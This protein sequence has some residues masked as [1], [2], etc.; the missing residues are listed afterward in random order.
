MLAVVLPRA[1]SE[2][3]A[4]AVTALH[5][6]HTRP[7]TAAAATEPGGQVAAGDGAVRKG[8]IKGG[9]QAVTLRG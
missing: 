9:E 8:G 6:S 5:S 1:V 3:V 2:R 7:P 4:S